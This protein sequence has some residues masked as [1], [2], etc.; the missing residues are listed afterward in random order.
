MCS[1]VLTGCLCQTPCVCFLAL[2]LCLCMQL[3]DC[4]DILTAAKRVVLAVD[5]D[6]PGLVLA[7]ELA[8]R[9]VG[10]LNIKH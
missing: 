10:V 1:L 9:W 5:S 4:S 3:D 6:Q 8:R 2:F 7:T